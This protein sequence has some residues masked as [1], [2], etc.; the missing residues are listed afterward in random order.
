MLS[1]AASSL[2]GVL[3]HYFLPINTD[4]FLK[5]L[6]LTVGAAWTYLNY[7]RGRTFRK[8]LDIKISGT[9]LQYPDVCV[10]SGA[11]H[12]KNIGLSQTNINQFGTG[13]TISALH[14]VEGR[15]ENPF[16]KQHE[17][18]VLPL[19]EK[20]GWVE[21]GETISDPFIAVLP[22]RPGRLLGVRTAVMISNGKI[23]WQ[24]ANIT[25]AEL[26]KEKE[27]E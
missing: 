15:G 2:S 10:F 14:Y 25:E 21:P 23:T 18:L 12:L 26:P 6:A 11:C 3:S 19:F 22:N 8:R 13:V 20:H 7:V 4:A 1:P 5:V 27:K 17:V 9:I 16:P 24:A